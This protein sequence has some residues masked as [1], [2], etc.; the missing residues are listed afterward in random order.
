MT[1]NFLDSLPE[2]LSESETSSGLSDTSS[3]LGTEVLERKFTILSSIYSTEKI[4]ASLLDEFSKVECLP[5][6]AFAKLPV[7]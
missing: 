4:Y 6:G 7:S 3:S 1:P 2:Q 5:R